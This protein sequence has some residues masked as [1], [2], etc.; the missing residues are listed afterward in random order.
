MKTLKDTAKE[1]LST[2]ERLSADQV[3]QA[4][5]DNLA[6]GDAEI[7]GIDEKGETLYRLTEQGRKN[8]ET[9]LLAN[10]KPDS[11]ADIQ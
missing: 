1:I 7:A 8:I 5:K 3:E 4:I 6:C 10:F 2:C 9:L 11:K